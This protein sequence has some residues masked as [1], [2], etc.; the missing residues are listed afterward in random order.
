MIT[1]YI[2][3]IAPYTMVLYSSSFE[4]GMWR[5]PQR[6]VLAD[7]GGSSQRLEVFLHLQNIAGYYYVRNNIVEH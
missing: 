7:L 6:L 5:L 1:F 4:N 2:Y 3:I